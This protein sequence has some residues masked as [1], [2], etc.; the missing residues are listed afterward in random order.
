MFAPS[1]AIIRPLR[2][3][4]LCTAAAGLNVAL[5]APARAGSVPVATNLGNWAHASAGT[6]GSTETLTVTSSRAY[7]EWSSFNLSAGNT[8]NVSGQT[9]ANWIL[10][11]KVVGGTGSTI[12]GNINAG[13]QVWI[14]DPNG[15]T[16]N[17]GA[18]LNVGGLVLSS[19]TWSASDRSNYLGGGTNWS[20]TGQ[21]SPVVMN[22]TVVT[23]GGGVVA[24]LAPSVNMG[25]TVNAGSNTQFVAVAAKDVSLGFGDNGTYFTLSGVSIGR[26]ADGGGVTFANGG[27]VSADRIVVAAAGA[28]SAASIVVSGGLTANVARGD[29]TDIVLMAADGT[30]PDSSPTAQTVLSGGLVSAIVT[31]SVKS[32]VTLASTGS[33]TATGATLASGG[34]IDLAGNISAT[35][36]SLTS[37]EGVIDQTAGL[38]STTSLTGSSW[39]A[40]SLTSANAIGTVS[41][42]VSGGDFNL[43]NS[44]SL[45]ASH[46]TSTG[47]NLT[48]KTTA[49]D[50]TVTGALATGAGDTLTLDSHHSISILT[51]L[52]V[53]GAGKVGI[54][55]DD[56]GTGGDYDFGLTSAG[57]HGSLSFT[58]GA[59]SGAGLT[60][61]GSSYTLVYSMSELDA[62]D[63]QNAVTGASE[64]V[65]GPGVAGNYAL[66][67]SLNASGTT[68]NNAVV[69]SFGGTLEGLGHALSNLKIVSTANDAGLFGQM[70]GD[71]RDLATTNGA[72]TGIDNVGILAGYSNSG[73]FLADYTT[74]SVNATNY[75]GGLIGNTYQATVTGS[76]STSS[77]TL[78]Q[79]GGSDTHAGGLIGHAFYTQIDNSWASGNINGAITSGGLVGYSW[80]SSIS[81]SYAT[82]SVESVGPGGSDAGGLIGQLGEG[83]V[84]SSYATGNVSVVSSSISGWVGGLIGEDYAGGSV[85]NSYATGSVHT[86]LVAG[87][88]M[89]ANDAGGV[90]SNSYSTGQ[91]SGSALDGGL[92]GSNAGTVNNSYWD[93]LTSGQSVSAGGTGMTTGQL[94]GALPTGFSPSIWGTGAG[95]YPYLQSFYPNGVQAITGTANALYPTTPLAGATLNFYKNGTD[96]GTTTTG[97]NGYYYVLVPAYTVNGTTAIGTTLSLAGTTTIGAIELI[98]RQDIEGNVVNNRGLELGRFYGWVSDPTWSS[99]VATMGST[100]G[101]GL[102]ASLKTTA[103]YGVIDLYAIAPSFTVDVAQDVSQVFKVTEVNH[104]GV[105][106]DDAPITVEPHATVMF[107]SYGPLTIDA[108]ISV[109]GNGLADLRYDYWQL[110]NGGLVDP[111]AFSFGSGDSVSFLTSTG[112]VATTSQGGLFNLNNVAYTLIYSMAQLDAIDG[113][114]GVTGASEGVYGPGLNGNYALANTLNAAGTTYAGDLVGNFEGT[115]EGLNNSINNLTIKDNGAT[116]DAVGLFGAFHGLGRDINLGNVSITDSDPNGYH[117]AVGGLAGYS[118]GSVYNVSVSGDVN[119]TNDPNANVGGVIGYAPNGT[120]YHASAS[121]TVEGSAGDNLGGLVGLSY[122]ATISRSSATGNVTGTNAI[123]GGLVGFAEGGTTISQSYATGN[124]TGGTDS[125]EGGLV[126]YN[127]GMVDQTFATGSVTSTSGSTMGGLIGANSGTVTNSYWD[128]DTSGQ[129]TSAGGSGLTSAQ[130]QSGALPAGFDPAIWTATPGQ[131]PKLKVAAGQ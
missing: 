93:T 31:G 114:N 32:S 27:S 51:N 107:I 79:L 34:D 40:T 26:G 9:G 45:T 70:S 86:N 33:L 74:G 21:A 18:S 15:V 24:L 63:G 62:I 129:S 55:T 10:V 68:Y 115:F 16:V 94:Q 104:T 13:G 25:G 46:V 61:N 36:T 110:T 35:N 14:I 83:S 113:I 3:I 50:L 59:S 122:A 64:A 120:I 56:G 98:D 5:G 30:G 130:L 39:G 96:I 38:V 76:Y 116:S 81:E 121:D 80:D 78:N 67:N 112:G 127:L 108:P 17:A 1:K 8:F 66:A 37:A 11:N 44:Q 41:N 103:A 119:A 49:G 128:T 2:A 99:T 88:L 111:S 106:I 60:I 19:A 53:P 90:I 29:G 77:V 54:V 71:V 43:S 75:A 7:A 126:G 109:K 131:N 101:A 95:L 102:F 97:A 42:F 105:L 22:G 28:T 57:F 124:V 65:Y 117:P 4:L 52:S 84:A 20:F 85:T 12:S 6:V 69:S 82:G 92:V 123:M 72:V 47:G 73:Q 23:S 125:A 48:L 87:G 89:G 100:F 58:G 91:V 118:D